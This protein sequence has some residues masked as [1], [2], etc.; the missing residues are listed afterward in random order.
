MLESLAHKVAGLNHVTLCLLKRQLQHRCF[1]V[2]FA[3]FSKHLSHRAP[4][5]DHFCPELLIT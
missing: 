1:P 5:D 4:P 3:E 2:N